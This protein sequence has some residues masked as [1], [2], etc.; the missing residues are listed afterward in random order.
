MGCDFAG[1][2]EEV[3]PKVTK[4]W[5]K[6]DRI[7]GF[8]HGVNSAEPED[9]AFGEYVMAKGDIAMKIPEASSFGYKLLHSKLPLTLISNGF[10]EFE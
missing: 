2:V 1:I 7:C 10:V 6:G 4:E 3:G 5:K 8:T 9:G